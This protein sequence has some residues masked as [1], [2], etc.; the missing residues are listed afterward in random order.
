MVVTQLLR[1]L[2]R[3]NYKYPL[4]RRG[5]AYF[6]TPSFLFHGLLDIFQKILAGL[7]A[8]AEADRRVKD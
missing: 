2:A 6:D 5:C 7:E 1:L 4:R 3:G 8:D